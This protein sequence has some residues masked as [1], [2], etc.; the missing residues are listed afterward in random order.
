MCPNFG[1]AKIIN[2][3]FGTNGKLIILGVPIL[4]HVMVCYS[5]SEN[6]GDCE[7]NL[8]QNGECVDLVGSYV[9]NC[10]VSFISARN[11]IIIL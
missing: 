10:T 5:C 9:C 4:K 8:C 7:D 2:F 1:T 11:L 3:P 6:I